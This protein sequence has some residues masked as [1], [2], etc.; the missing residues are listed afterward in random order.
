MA[1]GTEVIKRSSAEILGSGA[2]S[3]TSMF[4]EYQALAL[5]LDISSSMAS[6]IESATDVLTNGMRQS[7]SDL[8][9]EVVREYLRSRLG[10]KITTM[11]ISILGFNGGCQRVVS[12][13][14]NLSEMEEG[15]ASLHPSGNT[16]L[17][18]AIRDAMQIVMRNLDYVPRIVVT[19]DGA[20]HDGEACLEIARSAKEHGVII[21]TIFIGGAGYDSGAA[22]LQRLSEITG[23]VSERV[24]N[25]GEFKAKYLKVLDRK[26]IT[27]GKPEL[28]S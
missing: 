21:D 20:V 11:Q 10:N 5:V 7:K 9:K 22:F 27:S 13:S 12:N 2:K 15:L 6:S 4:D 24:N 17:A 26:L 14:S 25:S 8:Q 18:P 23:G 28:K 16:V 3:L 19:S 1:K